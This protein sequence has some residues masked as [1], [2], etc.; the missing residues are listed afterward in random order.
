MG[1]TAKIQQITMSIVTRS[2]TE[3]ANLN[4]LDT[5]YSSVLYCQ[6]QHAVLVTSEFLFLDKLLALNHPPSLA[7]N[8]FLWFSFS[9]IEPPCI[10]LKAI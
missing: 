3:N 10:L 9:T 5:T 2:L 1:Y 4:F 6:T 8:H 7:L